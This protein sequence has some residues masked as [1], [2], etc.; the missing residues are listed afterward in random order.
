MTVTRLKQ[1][2]TKAI[3]EIDDTHF[4]QALHT[5]VTS[6]QDEQVRYQLSTAQK[7]E[8]DLRKES[9]IKGKSKSYT[10][11]EVKKEALKK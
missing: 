10:W 1:D 4:L 2:L 11:A 6:R 7:N 5:I 9:H 3:N 8:L